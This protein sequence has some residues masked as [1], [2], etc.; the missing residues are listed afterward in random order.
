MAYAAL[1]T[2]IVTAAFGFAMFSIW[3]REPEGTPPGV[4]RDSHFSSSHVLAHL[5]L[6]A[7]GLLLWVIYL[8]GDS[9]VIAWISFVAIVLGAGLGDVL[10]L[11][12][13]RD[14]R[15]TP[16]VAPIDLSVATSPNVVQL[17]LSEQRIPAWLVVTHGVFAV[18]TLILVLLTA[19]SDST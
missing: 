12:W 11:R 17:D 9:T 3:M 15:Q 19:I 6:G 1:G 18:A 5:L 8:I 14:R 7:V 13:L 10:V 2:W 16:F 4:L